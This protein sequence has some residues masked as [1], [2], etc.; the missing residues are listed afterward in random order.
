[1]IIAAHVWCSGNETPISV[2]APSLYDAFLLPK[3]M[4]GKI[5]I[6]SHFYAA[7]HIRH[8]LIIIQVNLPIIITI[9]EM[10]VKSDETQSN[11]TTRRF[12]NLS[13]LLL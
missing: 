3:S 8:G 10:P 6:L 5:K 9:R 12:T 2:H 7:T 4:A 13:L 11:S 1:M